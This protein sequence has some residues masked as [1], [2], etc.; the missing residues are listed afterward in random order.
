ML[1]VSPK[2]FHVEGVLSRQKGIVGI[3]SRGIGN[4]FCVGRAKLGAEGVMFCGG[5]IC[6]WLLLPMAFKFCGTDVCCLIIGS[7]E[8]S[9][10]L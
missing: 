2:A 8:P 9:L 1:C 4:E 6:W 10:K 3:V 7:G 5:A